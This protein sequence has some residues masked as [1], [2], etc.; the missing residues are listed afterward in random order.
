MQLH[1]EVGGEGIVV[2]Q[3]NGHLPGGLRRQSLL[4]V[5]AG[6][7]CELLFWLVLEFPGL[8]RDQ[9]AL[10]VTLATHGHVLAQGH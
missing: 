4:F 6:E 2:G 5:E 1:L 9:R 10:A 8:L 3:L 7:F